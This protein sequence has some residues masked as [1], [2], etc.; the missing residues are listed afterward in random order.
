M[1]LE[2]REGRDPPLQSHLSNIRIMNRSLVEPVPM[3]IGSRDDTTSLSELRSVGKLFVFQNS[4]N[5]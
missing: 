2:H 5:T 3:Y 1:Q 4:I